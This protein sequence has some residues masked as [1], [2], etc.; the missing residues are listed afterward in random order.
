MTR[1]RLQVTE[2][3]TLLFWGTVLKPRP[4]H[5]VLLVINALLVVAAAS[6]AYSLGQDARAFASEL[7]RW[8]VVVERVDVTDL[9]GEA[10]ARDIEPPVFE[11]TWGDRFVELRFWDA[12]AFSLVW[13]SGSDD[14]PF[15]GVSHD[16]VLD[17][18]AFICGPE[19][20]ALVGGCVWG[21]TLEGQFLSDVRLRATVDS[22]DVEGCAD[23]GSFP[24]LLTLARDPQP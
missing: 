23:V 12:S 16:C 5:A 19:T 9:L 13:R 18:N 7:A 24:Y 21:K 22:F 14:R 17:G 10:V 15:V 1:G 4:A 6:G 20:V 8:R 11:G 2:L 3:A